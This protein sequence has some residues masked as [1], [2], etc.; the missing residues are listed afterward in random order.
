MADKVHCIKKTVRL[1]PNEAM[2]L[3]EKS[4]A[5]GMNEAEYIRFLISQ[6]PNDYPEIRTLLKELINEVNRVGVN[7]NQITF[8]HNAQLYSKEDKE[9]LVAYM[10]KLNLEVKKVVDMIGN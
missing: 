7:I 4:S 3:S 5:A 8:S 10:R 1:M 2:I 9:K 6:K